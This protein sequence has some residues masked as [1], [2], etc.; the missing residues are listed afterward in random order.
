MELGE[1]IIGICVTYKDA[2]KSVV[3]MNENRVI[4]SIDQLI[5]IEC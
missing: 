1:T 5:V 3:K 2:S 4:E